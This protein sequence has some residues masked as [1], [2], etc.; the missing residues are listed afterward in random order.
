MTDIWN[1]L[2]V[3][4]MLF[5]DPWKRVLVWPAQEEEEESKSDAQDKPINQIMRKV[6]TS[7]PYISKKLFP[8]LLLSLPSALSSTAVP[9]SRFRFEDVITETEKRLAKN[10]LREIDANHFRSRLAPWSPF[11]FAAAQIEGSVFV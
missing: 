7:G 3:S 11:L 8:V 6:F 10:Q 1:L 5:R 4:S 2:L 9:A